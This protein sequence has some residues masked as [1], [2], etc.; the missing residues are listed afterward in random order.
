MITSK[1]LVN[2]NG[3]MAGDILES[4]TEANSMDSEFFITS[5]WY[6]LL[7][8]HFHLEK[9]QNQNMVYGSTEST[10]NGLLMKISLADSEMTSKKCKNMNLKLKTLLNLRL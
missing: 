2:L 6:Q 5:M 4:G 8:K 7:N 10:Q 1:E 3:L 9:T